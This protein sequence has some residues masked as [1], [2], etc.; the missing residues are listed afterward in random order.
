MGVGVRWPLLPLN[1][2]WT[3]SGRGTGTSRTQ[4][5]L[6]SAGDPPQTL[7]RELVALPQTPSWWGEVPSPRTVPLL[8][9]LWALDR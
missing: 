8:S 4:E 9:A 6:L 5:K 7:L 3:S 1:L 2:T